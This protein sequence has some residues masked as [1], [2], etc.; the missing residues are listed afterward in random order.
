MYRA[1]DSRDC[2]AGDLVDGAHETESYSSLD[3]GN[4]DALR[5]MYVYTYTMES[6]DG[7]K[8]LITIG[9]R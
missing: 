3:T 7:C 6:C 8:D 1:A 2:R 5:Y 9:I 4:V